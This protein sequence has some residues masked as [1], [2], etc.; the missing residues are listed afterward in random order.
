KKS[1]ADV[2]IRW[3]DFCSEWWRPVKADD[4]VVII[5]LFL[6]LPII[7]VLALSGIGESW[8]WLVSLLPFLAIVLMRFKGASGFK[9][10]AK[11]P[12]DLPKKSEADLSEGELPPSRQRMPVLKR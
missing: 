9:S 12:A 8:I 5:M 3:I 4:K 10:E 7:G 1:P 6:T 11:G 2:C